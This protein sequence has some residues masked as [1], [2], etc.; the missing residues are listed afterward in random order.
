MNL[1]AFE[2]RCRNKITLTRQRLRGAWLRRKVDH[3]GCRLGV[4]GKVVVH[5]SRTGAQLVLG[6]DVFL[7]DNVHIALED[8]CARVQIGD[9]TFLGMRTELR[10]VDCISIGSDCAISWDVSLMDSDFHSIDG[11]AKSGPITIGDHVWIGS[12][13]TVLKGV[14]IGTGAIIAAG[15]VVTAD[16]PPHCV[17]AGV[18]ARVI[19][20]YATWQ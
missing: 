13:V 9:R 20:E 14:S 2:M 11:H 1:Q 3:C 16:V 6:N 8:E 17:A 7:Y 15:A 12:R 10:C 18:P 19:R 4:R 5:R